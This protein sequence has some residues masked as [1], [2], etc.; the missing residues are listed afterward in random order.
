MFKSQGQ[1]ITYSEEA[2]FLLSERVIHYLGVVLVFILFCFIFCSVFP[3]LNI[4]LFI[5]KTIH[6]FIKYI[7]FT[8]KEFV[9]CPP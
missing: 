4:I 5:I 8:M 7:T 6:L 2:M 9:P 1:G 3:S